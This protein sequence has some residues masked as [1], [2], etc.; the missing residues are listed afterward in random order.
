MLA[1]NKTSLLVPYQLPDFVRGSEDYANFVLFLKSYYEWMEENRG[2]V[3]DSKSIPEYWDVDTTI[4]EFLEYFKNDFMSFFPNDAL[5]D[6]RRLIKIAKELYQSKGIPASFQFLFRVLYNSDVNLYNTKDYILKASDGKWIATRSIRVSNTTPNWT[7]TIGYRVFGE[8]SKAYATVQNVVIN[9]KETKIVLSNIERNF[10]AGEYVKIVDVHGR[11]HSF[12]GYRPRARI[13]GSVA[14]VKINKRSRGVSYDV[15]DPVVFY[16]GLDPTIEI[17]IAANA[18]ISKVTSASIK[19][20]TTVYPGHGYRAGSFTEINLLSP[21]GIGFGAK[22]I[23]TKLNDEP[24]IVYYVPE[25]QI[26]PKANLYLGNTT[27]SWGPRPYGN[28]VYQFANNEFANAN[29]VIAEAL[30][31]PVLT[32]YGIE[33]TTITSAGTGYDGTTIASATGFYATESDSRAA[34]PTIGILPPIIIVDGGENYNVGDQIRFVGGSGYGA[35]ANVTAVQPETGA[36]TEITY[37]DDPAGR[38]IY[39]LGGMG[40]G[41]FLPSIEVISDTG[42]GAVLTVYKLVGGDAEFTV[43]GSPYGEILEV[44]ITEPGLNYVETPEISL[45]VQDLLIKNID[46]MPQNGDIIYQGN[47]FTNLYFRANVDSISTYTANAN[48]LLSVYSMRVY[49]YDGIL[50]SANNFSIWRGGE[51]VTTQLLLANTITDAKFTN[52]RKIYGNGNAK[53]DAVFLEGINLDEGQYSNQ[54]GFLSSYPVLQNKVYN[55]YTYMIQVE[56]ALAKY[57]EK[58]LGFLHPS[59]LNYASY[60]ILRN[61]NSYTML[62]EQ[63]DYKVNALGKLINTTSYVADMVSGSSNTIIFT[64]I[65]A[66]NIVNSIYLTSN[67]YI[68]LYNRRNEVLYSKIQSATANTITIRDNWVITVPNVATANVTANSD[69]INISNLTQAWNIATGNGV[70][71]FSD[72]MHPFDF[73]SIDGGNTYKTITSVDQPLYIL[74]ELIPPLRIRVNTAYANTQTANLT[75]KQNVMSSNIWISSLNT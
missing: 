67:S 50:N 66:A 41:K 32:T 44:T 11:T 58:V 75:F 4:T 23:L 74:G 55:E 31:F 29:T 19:G 21:P 69:Y 27:F 20:T 34:L 26:A 39:P 38:A 28:S 65:G 73:V 72:F 36:I 46:V 43:T 59:G 18:Y 45:R 24:H 14:T 48:T 40:Y 61:S 3:Y 12:D 17:P 9:D 56:E 10:E 33:E 52:G 5:V 60:N 57:K 8:T 68:T 13:I 2:V 25:D 64:N 30:T 37:V 62:V 35:Y 42:G 15:G 16:G 63:S 7:K 47:T 49:D 1:N 54:D 51:D 6:E 53:A 71:F 70:V 22:S